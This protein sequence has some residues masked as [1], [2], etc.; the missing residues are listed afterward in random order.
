MLSKIGSPVCKTTFLLLAI[1]AIPLQAAV[2]LPAIFADHMVIQRDQPVHVW[3]SAAPG[4]EVTVTFRGAERSTRTDDLGRWSVELPSGNAGGPFVLSIQGSDRIALSDVLV[5]DVWIASGQS[6]M[7]FAVKEGKN[8]EQELAGANLPRLRLMNVDQRPADYPQEDVSVLMPWSVSGPET[9][10]DFSAV[11]FFFGRELLKREGVP[12]GIIESAWGGTPAEA[13]TSMHALSQDASLMPVF[14]AWAA[15]QDAE[16]EAVL[17]QEKERRDLEKQAGTD[18]N[19]R[20]PWH[21]VFRSWAPA[22]LFNGMIAPLT[23]FP[24]RGVIW[25]QGE[26]NTD[27]MRYPVY[28]RLF[29]TLILDWRAQW[30]EGNFPFLYV[31]IANYRAGPQDHWPEIREAQRQAL[32]LVNTAMAVTIDIGDPENIHPADKQDVGHRLALAARAVAYHESVEDSGPLFRSVSREGSKLRLFFDHAND[33]LVVKG[34]QL[35]GFEIAGGDGHFVPAAAVVDGNAVVLSSPAVA[36]PVQARYG[37]A[38][39]PVCNLYNQA[40]LPASPF[41]SS[42]L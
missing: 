2:R 28:E 8:A 34:S 40:G 9:A 14:S 16:P 30:G 24:I 21:P 23:R 20:L 27:R 33:G 19:L 13:W 11:A 37:W 12:I 35:E 10:R 36:R 15:M 7:G 38:D 6:N 39:N 29:Q 4:E 1:A 18:E 26:S 32:R 41:R 31:Q 25:Y 17:A 22:A 5:G 3:G 42:P